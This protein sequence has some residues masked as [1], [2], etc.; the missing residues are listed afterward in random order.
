[1]VFTAKQVYE[2][3][4]AEVSV[5]GY[6]FDAQL[7]TAICLQESSYNSEAIR[8][9]NGFYNKYTRKEN[10]SP[11]VEILLAAS[12]G[13]MQTMGQMLQEVGYFKGLVFPVHR[14]VGL[15][16]N[17]DAKQVIVA[18]DNYVSDPAQQIK[19]G[20]RH[21]A[22]KYAHAG[23]DLGKAL[24]LWNGGGNLLYSSEVLNKYE[25]IKKELSV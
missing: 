16:S 8:L 14:L 10:L 4:H 7:V 6:E 25:Q 23:G 5:C 9:E 11:C 12:Y 1:M 21:F 17:L 22:N 18:L 19:Y 3:A 13:L 2:I 24:L 20:C 15:D